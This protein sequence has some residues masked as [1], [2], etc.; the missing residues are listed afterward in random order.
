[1]YIIFIRMAPGEQPIIYSPDIWTQRNLLESGDLILSLEP[2]TIGYVAHFRIFAPDSLE[3]ITKTLTD[4]SQDW[5]DL[6]QISNDGSD[7]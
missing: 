6:V 4:K 2:K 5:D 1:M 7:Y 3:I